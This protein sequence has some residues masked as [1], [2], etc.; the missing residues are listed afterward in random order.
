M[1]TGD[2]QTPP[3]HRS[4]SAPGI[5]AL[6]QPPTVRELE[7]LRLLRE[8]LWPKEI[9]RKLDI[10]Y[11]TVKRHSINLYRKLGGMAR[12]DAVNRTVEPGILPPR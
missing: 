3:E 1:V 2:M 9:T 4:R 8:L 7:I 10:S 12:W 5:S 6:V 11:L